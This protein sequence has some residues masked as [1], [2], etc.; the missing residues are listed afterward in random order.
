MD[1]DIETNVTIS[2][3][4]TN[5]GVGRVIS[6]VRKNL[7]HPRFVKFGLVGASG[8]A[9]NMGSLYLLTDFGKIPYF[10][11]SLIAIELSILSNFSVNLGWTWKDRAEAGTVWSKLLRYHIGV[12]ATA[13]LGN[14]LILIVMTELFGVYYLVSNLVGIAIGT[15]ANYVV[16]DLWTFKNR[17]NP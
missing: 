14:Y 11:A 5:S 4:E 16:N 3:T 15:L 8:I 10:I 2:D 17:V 12:G 13:L 7:F 6:Y 1:P 9:V